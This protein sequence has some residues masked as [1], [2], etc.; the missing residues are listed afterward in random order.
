[1]KTMEMLVKVLVVEEAVAVKA[2]LVVERMEK[3]MEEEVAV[4]I[5]ADWMV[6]PVESV[7][8]EMVLVVVEEVAVACLV[9]VWR[10]VLWILPPFLPPPSTVVRS[11]LATAGSLVEISPVPSPS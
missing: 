5:K 11:S 7:E 8:V 3:V 4:V 1:M 10:N 6:V 9:H 2:D